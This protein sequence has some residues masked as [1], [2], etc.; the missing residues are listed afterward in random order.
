MQSWQTDRGAH[1][2]G[3]G[4]ILTSQYDKWQSVRSTFAET[5]VYSKANRMLD[6]ISRTI[7]YRHPTVLLNLYKYLVRRT[8]SGLLLIICVEPILHQGHRTA[9]A[10]PTSRHSIFFRNF[11]ACHMMI[12]FVSSVCGLFRKGATELISLSFSNWSKVSLVFH[13]M[14]SS[15]GRRTLSP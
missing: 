3:K 14:N 2:R 15:T 8:T 10:S 11:E 7:R 13:G 5:I 4:T 9:R 1:N 12:G 6:L